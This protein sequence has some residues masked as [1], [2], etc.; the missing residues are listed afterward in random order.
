MEPS[1][2]DLPRSQLRL[3]DLATRKPTPFELIPDA[4]ERDAI[5]DALGIPQVRKLRFSGEIAPVGATDWR[6][7]ADLG[8]TVVQDCAITLDPVTSRIDETI[9]RSYVADLPEIDAAEIEMPD[10]DSV[11]GLPVSLDLAAVMI[12]ALSLALPPFPKAEGADLG[13]MIYT[14][15]GKTAL[16]DEDAKPFAGLQ[17]LRDA[18]TDKSGDDG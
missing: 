17:S 1:L 8:A 5:A 2:A 3:A 14:E 6:L 11:E 4:G 15:P 10:D 7:H 12:E 13:A 18:L 9:S 16:S